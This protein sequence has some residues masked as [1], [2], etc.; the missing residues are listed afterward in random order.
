MET[1]A[2]FEARF[3]PWSY[4]ADLAGLGTRNAHGSRNPLGRIVGKPP[5]E[6]RRHAVGH[7]K[8]LGVRRQVGVTCRHRMLADLSFLILVDD[9]EFSAPKPWA[10][11]AGR[12]GAAMEGA[13]TRKRLETGGARLLTPAG[14]QGNGEMITEVSVGPRFP[15]IM[16]RSEK[17]E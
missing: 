8:G 5:T 1:A 3:A 2:S 15:W 14:W 17:G 9:A 10:G 4:P 11:V 6:S 16:L 12:Y 13:K 7:K